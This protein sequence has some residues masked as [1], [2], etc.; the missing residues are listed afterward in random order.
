MALSRVG[1][2]LA[3]IRDRGRFSSDDAGWSLRSDEG[4][5]TGKGPF[6]LSISVYLNVVEFTSVERFGT[7]ERPD[8]GIHMALRR[9][10]EVIA[11]EFGAGGRLAI[12]AGGFGDTD[13]AGDLALA[14]GGF[15]EVCGC[16]EAVIGPPARSWA[17]LEA[18]ELR[19]YL[20]APDIQPSA[21]DATMNDQSQRQ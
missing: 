13:R 1:A 6:G 10:F 8:L 11:D 14:G 17:A 18:G 16:L 3:L 9:V 2:E 5:I 19:W 4:T 7:V 15:A 12:A 21:I 20:S